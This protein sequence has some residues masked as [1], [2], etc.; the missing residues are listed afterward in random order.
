MRRLVWA[1]AGALCVAG[2]AGFDPET[3]GL[4]YEDGERDAYR[5]Y[6]A[7]FSEVPF[8]KGAVSVVT[9]ERGALATYTLVPC[10]GGAAIC[11]GSAQGR[12]GQLERTPDYMIVRGLYGR[13]FWLSP[14]GDGAMVGGGQTVPLAW[15]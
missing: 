1:M 15:N 5:A 13:E 14:G 7:S 8:S 2:C 10:Q 6:A 4:D 12:A 3:A 11:A 9:T